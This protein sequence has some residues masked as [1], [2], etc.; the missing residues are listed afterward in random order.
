M[1]I[2]GADVF[3]APDRHT[4]AGGK[5]RMAESTFV[6]NRGRVQGGGVGG[7]FAL[8]PAC[9]A[10]RSRLAPAPSGTLAFPHSRRRV[11]G[12]R[13]NRTFVRWVFTSSLTSQVYHSPLTNAHLLGGCLIER[14]FDQDPEPGSRSPSTLT[15]KFPVKFPALH[16]PTLTFAYIPYLFPILQYIFYIFKHYLHF[17]TLSLPFS[18]PINP[19]SRTFSSFTSMILSAFL[20]TFSLYFFHIFFY[21][22][23]IKYY[24]QYT[25]THSSISLFFIIFYPYSFSF[26]LHFYSIFYS[27]FY[28]IF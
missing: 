1:P 9:G 17:S 5:F 27:I 22:F 2:K 4:S 7:A 16:C 6:L 10:P 18:L 28:Q 15:A 20:P 11:R 25:C 24:F 8:V 23:F 13:V 26:F 21:I 3:R 19:L 12:A 14:V